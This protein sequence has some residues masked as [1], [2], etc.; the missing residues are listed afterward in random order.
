MKHKLGKKEYILFHNTRCSKSRACLKIIQEK[1]VSFKELHYLKEGLSLLILK[2]I[3]PETFSPLFTK[4]V[5]N[6]FNLAV[7]TK[8][9]T[10][11]SEFIAKNPPIA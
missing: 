4:Y 9:L 6:I 7:L 10:I 8:E 1:Q 3:S 5:S 11:I 2:N